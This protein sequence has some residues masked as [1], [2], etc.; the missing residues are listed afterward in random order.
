MSP[1]PLFTL[2]T[3]LISWILDDSPRSQKKMEGLSIPIF[4]SDHIHP[5][6]LSAKTKFFSPIFSYSCSFCLLYPE[7]YSFWRDV[8]DKN[9]V[10]TPNH[11]ISLFFSHYTYPVHLIYLLRRWVHSFSHK[12]FTPFPNAHPESIM[13]LSI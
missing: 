10:Q 13:L 5:L 3:K 12:Y 9:T 2:L 8:I 6:L 4:P 1:A 11:S 7:H